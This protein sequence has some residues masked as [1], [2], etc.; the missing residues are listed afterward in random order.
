MAFLL[1]TVDIYFHIRYTYIVLKAQEENMK[2]ETSKRVDDLLQKAVEV[3][4]SE[5][6]SLQEK[7]EAIEDRASNRE[8]G[9]MTEREKERYE[10][11]EDE[12]D[13]IQQRI[14]DIENVQVFLYDWK[15]IK[16]TIKKISRQGKIIRAWKRSSW[17][18]QIYALFEW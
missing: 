8:S 10:A 1:I 3:L 5:I 18:L 14:D 4:E 6:E 7:M 2:K 15:I 16:K 17:W 11:F 13:S 12:V 9:E